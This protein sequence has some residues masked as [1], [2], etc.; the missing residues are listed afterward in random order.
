MYARSGNRM[1]TA[2]LLEHLD[3]DALRELADALGLVVPEG[4]SAASLRQHVAHADGA[5]LP[6]VLAALSRDALKNVCK[7][8]GLTVTGSGKGPYVRA[9]TAA[10]AGDASSSARSITVDVLPRQPRLAWQGMEQR[11]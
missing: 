4:A 6:A 7:A 10:L 1:D 5:P 2:R 3:D 8:M 11:E 9:L